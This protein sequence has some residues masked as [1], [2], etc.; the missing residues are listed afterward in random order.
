MTMCELLAKVRALEAKVAE[1]EARPPVVIHMP[2]APAV[3]T[4]DR[5]LPW[6]YTGTT[7]TPL[8]NFSPPKSIWS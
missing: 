3:L 5:G 8:P 7:S 1:L 2:P 4:W 6:P